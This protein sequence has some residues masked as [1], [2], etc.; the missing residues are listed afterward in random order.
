MNQSN[1]SD[2]LRL[3]SGC[4]RKENGKV[5]KMHKTTPSGASD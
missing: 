2:I 3:K 5:Q 1:K 4:S